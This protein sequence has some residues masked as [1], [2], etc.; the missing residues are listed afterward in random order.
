MATYFVYYGG[1]GLTP[2][3]DPG[4]SGVWS[5]AYSTFAAAVSAAT[6]AGDVIKVSQSH[7]ED[8]GADVIYTIGADGLKII[9]VSHANTAV[10]AI[11]DSATN[12]VGNKTIN[13]A[14]QFIADAK[15]VFIYG[16]VF[17]VTNADVMAFYG[18]GADYEL[19]H[20]FLRTG[21]NSS[22]PLRF[23]TGDDYGTAVLRH[24][25]HQL[26]STS[27][28]GLAFNGLL[29]FINCAMIPD[30]PT[31]PV[32]YIDLSI[33]DMGGGTGAFV[34]CDMSGLATNLWD[35]ST[36][37]GRFNLSFANCK[38]SAS[39]TFP[40]SAD[41]DATFYDCSSGDEH[42]HFMHV[43]DRGTLTM[44][45][46]IY[47][48]DGAEYDS[49]GSKYS[50]KIVTTAVASFEF[51]YR[52]PLLQMHNEVVT[53]ITPS[54]EILRDGSATAYQDDE[55]WAEFSYKGTAG[56]TKGTLVSDRMSMLGTPAN[57]A[58]G[59]L[60]AAGWTGEGATAWFG[61]L[62]PGASITPAEIGAL[63][64]RVCVGAPSAT[65]YVDPQIRA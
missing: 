65:V 27:S 53:A 28:I 30:G 22:G 39:A 40:N 1:D 44:S 3:V 35:T 49:A 16:M 32:A 23:G 13:R 6:T 61:K 29:Q 26:Q 41:F 59:A 14:I 45:N 8:L 64:A 48:N 54:L 19:E 38:L 24:C 63:T 5:G 42:F 46:T 58:T 55:V 11:M 56:S 52:T 25:T 2:T 18:N 43:T 31:L 57:Q 51:P 10:A 60:G 9:C 33:V 15:Q 36:A 47:A 12:Y 7:F 4:T 17:W 20:C 21:S 37:S 34:N 62:A 50:W